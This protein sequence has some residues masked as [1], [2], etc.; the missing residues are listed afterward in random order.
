MTLVKYGEAH[1]RFDYA[2]VAAFHEQTTRYIRSRP[3]SASPFDG[4]AGARV[5]SLEQWRL[6]FNLPD[7]IV[8]EIREWQDTYADDPETLAALMDM[9]GRAMDPFAAAR[10]DMAAQAKKA[11]F[12][13]VQ[14]EAA[15]RGYLWRDNDWVH[16]DDLDPWPRGGIRNRYHNS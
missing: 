1:R 5:N 6:C 13:E 9:V 2:E 3:R 15:Q 14:I 16:I 4:F 7:P 10:R 11:Q 8:H 12:I